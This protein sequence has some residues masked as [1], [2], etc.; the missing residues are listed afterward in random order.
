MPTLATMSKCWSTHASFA[1]APYFPFIEKQEVRLKTQ[2]EATLWR[3]LNKDQ[4]AF[5]LFKRQ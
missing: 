3:A 2:F 4:R 1:D 5:T